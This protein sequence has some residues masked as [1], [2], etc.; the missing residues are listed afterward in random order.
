MNAILSQTATATTTTELKT[1]IYQ[2]REGWEALTN[3]VEDG[4]GYQVTTHKTKGGIKSR[5]QKGT[6]ENGNFSF[7]VFSDKS[8]DL[9]FTAVKCTENSVKAQ[10]H[11]ALKKFLELTA[12]EPK[13]YKIP[14]GQR[15]ISY[16]Y[17]M[18]TENENFVVFKINSSISVT[19]V[20]LDTLEIRNFDRVRDIEEVFGIG[21]YYKKDDV[22]DGSSE[23]LFKIVAQAQEKQKNELEAEQI[24][25]EEAKQKRAQAIE[26]GKKLVSIPSGAVSVIIAEL[27]QDDSDSQ[28][29]YFAS[30]STQTIYLAFSSHKKDLFTEMRKA[31]LN[32]D[33]ESIREFAEIPTVDRNDNPKTEQNAEYWHPRDEHREKYSMG[34]GYY[35]GEPYSRSGWR[36]SKDKFIKLQNNED[37]YI[38][39]SEGRYFCNSEIEPEKTNFEAVEVPAGEI[40]I[41][42]YSEKSF[43]IIGETKPIKDHL[44]EL[45][46]KFNFRLS[47]GAGWIF[48]KTKLQ[49]VTDFLTKK[50]Q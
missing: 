4:E 30:H 42:D 14:I 35:L 15:L 18:N 16:G 40:Q 20:D 12:N 46:G 7:M 45:G 31:C 24:A 21:T 36:I 13:P 1:R 33:I 47:C 44:K 39:A 43:A 17:G 26:E 37:L 3:S 41:V 9:L 29:D 34:A 49:E 22:F 5:A 25:R 2:G 8:I 48:P 28:S 6:F 19:A 38:A 32:C 10:H 23:E 50:A 11:E 27:M